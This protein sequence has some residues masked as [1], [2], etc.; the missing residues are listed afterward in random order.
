MLCL[1]LTTMLNKGFVVV[2]TVILIKRWHQ[3]TRH[4]SAKYKTWHFF[5]EEMN[6]FLLLK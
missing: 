3:L 4:F 1:Q 2:V 5:L 6:L